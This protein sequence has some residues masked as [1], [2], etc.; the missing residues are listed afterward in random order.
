MD[1]EISDLIGF[2]L[3]KQPTGFINAFNTLVGQRALD[4]I[5]AERVEV[6]KSYFNDDTSM[7]DEELESA[8]QGISD[9]EDA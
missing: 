5:E 8:L 7:S 6:A 9:N 1:N 3:A 4:A 2:A